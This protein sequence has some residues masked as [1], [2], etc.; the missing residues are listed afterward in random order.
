MEALDDGHAH[1]ARS[2]WSGRGGPAHPRAGALRCVRQVTATNRVTQRTLAPPAPGSSRS[3]ET[4]NR[5][6]EG[7]AEV[8]AA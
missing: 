1:V 2:P 6:A 5:E 3:G 4:G 7:E 8:A